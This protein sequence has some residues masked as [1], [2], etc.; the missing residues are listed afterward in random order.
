LRRKEEGE[1]TYTPFGGFALV[2]VEV[3]AGEFRPEIGTA[4]EVGVDADG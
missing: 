3:D 4:P 1:Q 2:D